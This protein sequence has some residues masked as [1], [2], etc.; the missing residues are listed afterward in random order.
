MIFGMEL[1]AVCWAIF[2]T[3]CLVRGSNVIVYLYQ[4][5]FQG[6]YLRRVADFVGRCV[7]GD[8]MAIGRVFRYANLVRKS[9]SIWKPVGLSVNGD[10]FPTF[11]LLRPGRFLFGEASADLLGDFRPQSARRSRPPPLRYENRISLSSLEPRDSERHLE[12]DSRYLHRS[13]IKT[14]YRNLP[15]VQLRRKFVIINLLFRK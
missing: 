5:G 2:P 1:T 13:Y 7:L 9:M 6:N 11:P 14:D 10:G 12:W 3:R 15:E 8:I 4:F